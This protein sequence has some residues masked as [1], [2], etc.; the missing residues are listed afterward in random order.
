MSSINQTTR[1]KSQISYLDE[2]NGI[3]LSDSNLFEE[4]SVQSTESIYLGFC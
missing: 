1:D 3:Y 2:I 4:K